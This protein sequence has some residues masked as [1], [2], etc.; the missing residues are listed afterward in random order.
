MPRDIGQAAQ[1]FRAAG[2]EEEL[3]E[4]AMLKQQF[5]LLDLSEVEPRPAEG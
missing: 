2:N 5:A 1:L 4:L 3:R